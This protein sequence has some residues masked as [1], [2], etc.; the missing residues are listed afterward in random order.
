MSKQIL[1]A[2]RTAK[3]NHQ[4]EPTKYAPTANVKRFTARVE[5]PCFPADPRGGKVASGPN[6][7]LVSL[8][9]RPTFVVE[10]FPLGRVTGETIMLDELKQLVLLTSGTS[11]KSSVKMMSA[12]YF[13]STVV[14][15]QF[16]LLGPL[17][18]RVKEEKHTVYCAAPC[19]DASTS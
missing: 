6:V 15:S 14:S 7:D 4:R 11:D 18:G 12:H 3:D 8:A 5:A 17:I 1:M 13:K 9:S 19:L 2:P 10:I 16:S